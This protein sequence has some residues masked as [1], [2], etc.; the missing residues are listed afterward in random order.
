MVGDTA[1]KRRKQPEPRA[2]RKSSATTFFSWANPQPNISVNSAESEILRDQKILPIISGIQAGSPAEKKQHLIAACSIIED[3]ICR[4]LLLKQH[5]I[6]IILDKVLAD[7]SQEVVTAG[8]ALL[9]KIVLYEGYDISLHLYRKGIFSQITGAI[10]TIKSGVF[11]LATQPKSLSPSDQTLL[12]DYTSSVLSLLT[13]LSETT[14]EILDRVSNEDVLLLASALLGL[15]IGGHKISVPENVQI[16]AVIL[17]DRVTDQNS[18][19]YDLL[20]KDPGFVGNLMRIYTAKVEDAPLKIAATCSTLHNV[21]S[22]SLAL[23]DDL[24]EDNKIADARLIAPLTAIIQAILSKQSPSQEEQQALFLSLETL[25]DVADCTVETFGH[26]APGNT[27]GIQRK[28]PG[29]RSSPHS[30]LDMEDDDLLEGEDEDEDEDDEENEED[31]QEDDDDDDENASDEE[32]PDDLGADMAM[33]T[34]EEGTTARASKKK[35]FDS[36]ELEFLLVATIPAVLPI[37]TST[38]SSEPERNIKLTTISLLSAIARA[39]ALLC[40]KTHKCK[41]TLSQSLQQSYLPSTH[42][43]WNILITPIL[44]SN[45]ADLKLAEKIT[46]LASHITAFTPSVSVSNNQHKSFLALYNAT[47]SIPL[48]VLCVKVLSNLARCQGTDR[49]EV[50]KELGTF[51]MT[52]VNKLPFY[53]DAEPADLPA[54]E[55]IIECLN[56]VYDVYDDVDNDY[57]EEVFV[58]LGFLKYLKSFV[59]RL[60]A[61]AKKVDRRTRFELRESADEALINLTEFIKYKTAEREEI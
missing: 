44:C 27:N 43:I 48:K 16:A 51:F 37:A 3:P 57:D 14:K 49:I 55:V 32:L 10:T 50:N 59:G 2:G 28:T 18:I 24:A 56:A 35:P 8:W 4:K 9:N 60:R 39:F 20:V 61:M 29:D 40:S 21:I 30:D 54:P 34:G 52:T 42:E 33:V 38:S 41:F 22:Q 11:A 19:A 17:L 1:K 58:K 26:N 45:S 5:I 13:K 12:W 23:A 46:E 6:Q 31:F 47:A 25:S 7:S 36:P 53:G 15:K